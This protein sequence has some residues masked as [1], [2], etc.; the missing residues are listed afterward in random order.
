MTDE[1]RAIRDEADRAEQ[2][3]E[4]LQSDERAKTDH[5]QAS[6]DMVL[7]DKSVGRDVNAKLKKVG[8]KY[9]VVGILTHRKLQEYSAN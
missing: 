9:V 4:H 2:E 6:V 3:H 1:E 8:R 5:S 7:W